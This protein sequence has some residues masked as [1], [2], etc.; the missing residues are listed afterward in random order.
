[1]DSDLIKR[2]NLR[3]KKGKQKW[4]RNIDVTGLE[5]MI[6]KNN[7]E[8]LREEQQKK[9][10]VTKID[11]QIDLGGSKNKRA[12]LDKDRF[13]KKT[14]EIKSV[15]ERRI[16]E[17]QA[18]RGLDE[19]QLKSMENYKKLKEDYDSE[20]EEEERKERERQN[21]EFDAWDTEVQKVVAA[22]KPVRFTKLQK[23]YKQQEIGRV[24][25][26]KE[27]QSYNPSLKAHEEL[28]D[29]IVM[30]SD[31]IKER[32]RKIRNVT[33]EKLRFSKHS[34]LIALQRKFLQ[35]KKNKPKT[36]KAI[37][38]QQIIDQQ[39]AQKKLNHDFTLLKKYA[40]EIDDKQKQIE[41]NI[42]IRKNREENERLRKK[43]GIFKKPLRLNKAI[44]RMKPEEIQPENQIADNLRYLLFL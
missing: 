6:A 34:K 14:G 38:H 24:V 3:A 40:R 37:L 41:I 16:I 30:K 17:K 36:L 22:E 7:L 21:V 12:K 13:V 42:Q 25:L 26:P 1:M 27:G 9:K 11:Y 4:K 43:L 23:E 15:Y 44:Y 20:I 32:Q 33:F 8:K 35:S 29:E 39:R 2:K 18:E 28:V 19:H 10:V 5:E 31:I